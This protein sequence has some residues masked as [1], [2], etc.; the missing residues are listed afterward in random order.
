MSN[1]TYKGKNYDAKS[2]EPVVRINSHKI[3]TNVL[4]DTDDRAVS[5]GDITIVDP[6]KVTV[7]GQWT[8][9]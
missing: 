6:A 8:I 3:L 5:A 9:V 4:I 1:Q 2:Y 7:K